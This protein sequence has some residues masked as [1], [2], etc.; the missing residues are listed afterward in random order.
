MS[1]TYQAVVIGGAGQFL[2][3]WIATGKPPYTLA[4]VHPDRFA[5]PIP[6][7]EAVQRCLEHYAA[8]YATPKENLS[9]A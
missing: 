1:E 3:D 4:A 2:S 9:V 7:A 5:N 8:G 6:R